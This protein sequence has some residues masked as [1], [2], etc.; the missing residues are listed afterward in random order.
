MP[1]SY[2][3]VDAFDNDPLARE[4]QD[5]GLDGMRDEDE[6]LFFEE[7]YINLIANNPALGISSIAYNNAVNDPSGDNFHYYMGSDFDNLETPILE[8]YK[9][10]NNPEGNSATTEQTS[11]PYSTSATSLPNS[12]DINRDNTL[13]ES[14]SYFQ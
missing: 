1:T 14:E 2:S 7:S 6:R 8:R 5:V 11:E 3:I 12:E 13:G 9:D 10:F 4:F